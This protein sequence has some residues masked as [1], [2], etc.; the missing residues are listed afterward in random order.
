V[1]QPL[2]TVARGSRAMAILVLAI[3]VL[4]AASGPASGAARSAAGC[5]GF[6]ASIMG[7]GTVVNRVQ[8]RGTGCETAR[9]VARRWVNGFDHHDGDQYCAPRPQDRPHVCHVRHWRCRARGVERLD[10]DEV[11]CRRGGRA[12]SWRATFDEQPGRP[13]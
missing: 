6:R 8:A 12:A 5:S 1:R 7:A 11:H 3:G 10:L 13:Y 2:A 4:A 9:A